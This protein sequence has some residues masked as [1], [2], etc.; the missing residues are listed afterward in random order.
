[1][2]NSYSN[3]IKMLRNRSLTGNKIKY[4]IL[5]NKNTNCLI[6]REKLTSCFYTRAYGN[7][8]KSCGYA[9]FNNPLQNEH[10]HSKQFFW[11]Y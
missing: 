4:D 9:A 6:C 5:F 8:C 1:M 7:F 10:Y 3:T 2:D 11:N